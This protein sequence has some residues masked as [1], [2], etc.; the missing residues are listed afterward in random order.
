MTNSTQETTVEIDAQTEALAEIDRF[1]QDIL[2]KN[3]VESALV[4]DF[5]LDIRQILTRERAN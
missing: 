1:L 4:Q 5:A 3:L 2:Y